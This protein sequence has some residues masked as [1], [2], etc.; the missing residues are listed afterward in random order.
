MRR[1]AFLPCFPCYWEKNRNGG[2][3]MFLGWLCFRGD[4]AEMC[5]ERWAHDKYHLSQH[6]TCPHW[7]SKTFSYFSVIARKKMWKMLIGY[8]QRSHS[9]FYMFW[10]TSLSLHC[11]NFNHHS[12]NE[13]CRDC[14]N[15]HFSYSLNPVQFGRE[16]HRFSG[17]SPQFTTINTAI[18][19]LLQTTASF[20]WHC[21]HGDCIQSRLNERHTLWLFS[22][23]KCVP[24]Q[25]MWFRKSTAPSDVV[26]MKSTWRARYDTLSILQRRSM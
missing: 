21:F 9:T 10:E 11:F 15:L 22:P 2:N 18:P 13:I 6:T 12:E 26:S 14:T 7:R 3:V 4:F 1:W 5:V 19:L 25:S 8:V 23:C 16:V 17:A 20:E 24:M